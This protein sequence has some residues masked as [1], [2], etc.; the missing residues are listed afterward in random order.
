MRGQKTSK[1]LCIFIIIFNQ[2]IFI[3]MKY[4]KSFLINES[5]SNNLHDNMDD[6]EILLTNKLAKLVGNN[7]TLKVSV[8]NTEIN[9]LNNSEEDNEGL[10]EIYSAGG[11]LL[12]QYLI[13]LLESKINSEDYFETDGKFINEISNLDN[14][15]YSN[16][17][18]IL[19]DM[20]FEI[21]SF[22]K[23]EK[24]GINLSKNQKSQIGPDALFILIEVGISKNYI[25]IKDIIVRKFKN[26]KVSG[27]VITGIK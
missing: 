19:G 18:W 6:L 10:T 16:Y 13:H 5:F 24:S 26:L 4:I 20:R 21:K 27:K 7:N 2:N 9:F 23:F 15:T 14:G 3:Y 12:Q 22:H 17:D 25:M 8:N 1:E 11:I